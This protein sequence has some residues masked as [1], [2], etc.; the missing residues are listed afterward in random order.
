ML[1]LVNG[2]GNVIEN[3]Q[4]SNWNSKHIKQFFFL[5]FRNPYPT[6]SFND[7][8]IVLIT[9][10][11]HALGDKLCIII[12]CLNIAIINNKCVNCVEIF[13]GNLGP[14]DIYKISNVNFLWISKYSK[15]FNCP[16]ILIRAV[17]LSLPFRQSTYLI[18][19]NV[20]Y[21]ININLYHY[22]VTWMPPGLL[23]HNPWTLYTFIMEIKS[24]N[25]KDTLSVSLC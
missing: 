1:L 22:R 25:C 13:K 17:L 2:H 4:K 10:P 7:S 12:H 11:Y 6:H 21:L 15:I 8:E 20:F 14:Q 5:F 9:C 3:H 16:T 24:K 18:N 19:R 23:C